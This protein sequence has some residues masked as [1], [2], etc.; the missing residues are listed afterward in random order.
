MGADWFTCEAPGKDVT[1]AFTA[2]VRDAEFEHGHGGYTGTIAE[3]VTYTVIDRVMRTE[4]DA[5]QFAESLIDDERVGDKWG[6]CGALPIYHANVV[7]PAMQR[8]EEF[9]VTVTN[10]QV[11]D[12]AQFRGEVEQFL[13]EV[14]GRRGRSGEVVAALRPS[15]VPDVQWK[16]SASTGTAGARALTRYVVAG[17]G[18]HETW[19]SGFATQAEARAW[20]VENIA[21]SSAYYS[22]TMYSAGD[23]SFR[24]EAVTRR[25]S[26]EPLVTVARVARKAT[27]TVKVT[28]ETPAVT[29]GQVPRE[30]QGWL[31]FGWASS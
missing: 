2:A 8:I 22:G 17:S 6:P 14:L 31:F 15:G 25:D 27:W 24:I 13:K 11:S 26:D 30:P 18:T 7:E 23:R 21:A 1:E 9:T 29:D 3:K 12:P 20:A 10:K 28:F 16:V 4:E 5:L 19:A